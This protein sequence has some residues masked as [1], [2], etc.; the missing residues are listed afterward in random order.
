MGYRW[1]RRQWCGGYHATQGTRGDGTASFQDVGPGD[2]Q[3]EIDASG[4]RTTQ[5]RISVLGTGSIQTVYVYIQP[6]SQAANTAPI[7]T[8]MTPKLQAEVDKGLGAMR[9]KQYEPVLQHFLRA[10]RM[11]PA[12]PDVVYLVGT[13]QYALNN[14]D[15]ARDE[16]KKALAVAPSHERALMALGELELESGDSAGAIATLEGAF[17]V[18]GADRRT[19]LLLSAAYFRQRELAK[20]QARAERAVALGK[21][22]NAPA[23]LLLGQVLAAQEAA[24]QTRQ[25]IT[26]VAEGWREDAAALEAQKELTT[27][28]APKNSKEE[29]PVKETKSLPRAA[30]EP[31]AGATQP[32]AVLDR[33]WAPPDTDAMTYQFAPDVSCKE[34]D[35][36]EA[37]QRRMAQ[38]LKNF[39]K[40]TATEQIEHQEI[41]SYGVPRDSKFKEFCYL[42]FVKKPPSHLLYLDET[43]DG[44]DGVGAILTPAYASDFEFGCEGLS[45][46]RQQAAWQIR[47]EQKKGVIPRVRTWRKSG[48]LYPIPLKGRIWIAANSHE[49]LHLESDVREPVPKLD[50]TKDHLMI[51]YGPVPFEHDH[52]KLWLPW[53]AEM[54]MELHGHRCARSE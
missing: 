53:K 29:T 23:R 7:G 31:I 32:P 33:M 4:Y 25:A 51:D 21:S 13:A 11:A 48:A 17:A 45:S 37:A 20:A 46:W 49:L 12:N 10:E 1:T 22:P 18:N 5:D 40:F 26:A 24:Q 9:K 43:R 2:Y 30:A 28:S 3:V 41:D 27:A 14:R 36:L 42:V 15:A 47:F 16:Y 8:V 35:V 44:S 52:E 34:Q 39:E 54:F 50:L 19:Y 6:K 38:Q